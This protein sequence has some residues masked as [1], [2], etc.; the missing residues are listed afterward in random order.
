MEIKL[1][2]NNLVDKCGKDEEK[3][4]GKKMEANLWIEENKGCIVKINM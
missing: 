3:E 1:H 2:E 4:D